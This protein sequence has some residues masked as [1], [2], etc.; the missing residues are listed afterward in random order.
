MKKC[1]KCFNSDLSISSKK[2]HKQYDK[3]YKN[4]HKKRN[5]EYAECYQN[6]NKEYYKK[7]A[8]RYRKTNKE[9]YREYSKKYNNLYQKNKKQKDILYKI[10]ANLRTRISQTLS[11]YSKSKSTL[12]I[13]G[14]NNFIEFKQYIES[15]FKNGMDWGNYGLGKNKWVID[16]IIPISLAL[17]ELEVYKLNHHTNLQPLWCDEN[18]VKS[19]K[20]I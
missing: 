5:K 13:L 19:N 9:Y 16:H 15:K 2:Y 3:N 14:L 1:K 20:T 12:Q 7:Y 6:N 8:E 18:I 11:G 17:T 4:K 10:G